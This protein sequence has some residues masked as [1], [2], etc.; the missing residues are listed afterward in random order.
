MVRQITKIIQ[1][2][3]TG[4][5]KTTHDIFPKIIAITKHRIN[6]IN[7]VELSS[8]PIRNA[9]LGR[10]VAIGID[11]CQRPM[12]YKYSFATSVRFVFIKIKIKAAKGINITQ[13]YKMSK[14]M[15]TKLSGF[16][17]WLLVIIINSA[18]EITV[19][20]ARLIK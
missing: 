3:T 11:R 6:S 17:I 14:K 8:N 12:K 2:Y 7:S 16:L 20:M 13:E 9:I 4:L 10:K 15:M 19:A 5:L 18:I 1:K